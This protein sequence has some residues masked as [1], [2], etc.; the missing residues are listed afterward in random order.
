MKLSSKGGGNLIWNSWFKWLWNK[1]LNVKKICLKN[2]LG[3][4]FI[5][6]EK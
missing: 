3:E 5:K 2:G 1:Y 6:N 4:N